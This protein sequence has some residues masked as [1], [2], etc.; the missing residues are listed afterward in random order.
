M[1]RPVLAYEI[2][3]LTFGCRESIPNEGM[4]LLVDEIRVGMFAYV[5]ET[6]VH[7]GFVYGLVQQRA[8]TEQSLFGQLI[9]RSRLRYRGSRQCIG[10]LMQ[11]FFAPG[12]SVGI[13]H[14]LRA[15]ALQPWIFD[16]IQLVR[17]EQRYERFMVSDANLQDA[18]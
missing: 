1:R 13:R 7:F 11:L 16:F 2:W 14:E 6:Y 8:N 9:F 3:Y 12:S 17:V 18:V 4:E 10:G 5:S 15:D